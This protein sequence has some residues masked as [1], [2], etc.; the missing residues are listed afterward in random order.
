[1]K[2]LAMFTKGSSLP[3]IDQTGL[4]RNGRITSTNLE[5]FLERATS[6]TGEG[7]VD[8]AYL[9][10]V[11]NIQEVKIEEDS[12]YIKTSKAKSKISVS[13]DTNEFPTPPQGE[14]EK[15]GILT[16][17]E[18]DQIKDL[19]VFTNN[20]ELRP[21][22]SGVFVGK[23]AIVA[24]DAH[25]LKYYP[26]DSDWGGFIIPKTAIKLLETTEYEV[27]RLMEK[28]SEWIRATSSEEVLTFRV[29][30][31][32]YPEWR[33]VVP[34]NNPL[35]VTF[36]SK[37]LREHLTDALPNSNNETKYVYLQFRKDWCKISSEDIDLG[38]EYSGIMPITT[39][40]T[41]G[42][43]E[44]I[45]L[46]GL[47][48]PNLLKILPKVGYAT[49]NWSASNRAVLINKYTLLMS[50]VIHSDSSKITTFPES[51]IPKDRIVIP[52]EITKPKFTPL[53]FKGMKIEEYSTKAVVIRG[54]TKENKEILKEH[55]ARFNP[56]LT[57][58]PGWILSKK[59]LPELKKSCS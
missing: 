17:E 48:I 47:N 19:L 16:S 59:V 57:G 39:Q 40:W 11:K 55:R 1:M 14:F 10:K 21:V 7:V 31:G 2:K 13:G 12:V 6:I 45:A 58:G 4:V 41:E 23:D 35:T 37:E 32:K 29:V 28:E 26:R 56:Y 51:E 42:K 20:D 46:I 52:V 34:E 3:I 22:M 54:K 8:L 25:A 18:V 15:L 27:E 36:D 30:D 9:A 49:L 50:V 38:R 44:E 43:E 5:C 33:A 53:S 24:T